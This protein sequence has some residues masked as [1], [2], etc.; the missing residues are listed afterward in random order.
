M[1]DATLRDGN[2]LREK[3]VNHAR[4][5]RTQHATTPSAAQLPSPS[6]IL[7]SHDLLRSLTSERLHHAYS[8]PG[9]PPKRST[10]G[11][12]PHTPTA[13]HT[14]VLNNGIQRQERMHSSA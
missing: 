2:W 11:S 1:I 12:A 10:S 3:Q 8:R 9:G 5:Q 6:Q 7:L 4:K 13:P 14:N